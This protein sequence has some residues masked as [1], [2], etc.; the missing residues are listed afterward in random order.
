MAISGL[1]TFLWF[2]TEA[3]EA[4][5]YYCDLFP[6]AALKNVDYYPE[7]SGPLSGLPLTVSFELF[8]TSFTALNGGPGHPHSDAVSFQVTCD[9]QE[10]LDTIWNALIAEGGE[11]GAC[12]WCKDRWG[13]SWQVIPRRLG[14]LLGNP[15][16]AGKIFPLMPTFRKFDIA[17]LNRA[18]GL[19]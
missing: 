19:S 16:T 9:T 4:A 17:E 6:E 12:G 7:G 10:E 18:A 15:D 3:L 13:V 1:T 5:Q 2:E 11:G 14:E 8:G